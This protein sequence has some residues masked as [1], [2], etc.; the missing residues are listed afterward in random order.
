MTLEG[1]LD[2]LMKKP[3]ID[4]LP[5]AAYMCALDSL[6]D[7]SDLFEPVP[8]VSVYRNYDGPD[9]DPAGEGGYRDEEEVAA[10]AGADQFSCVLV[11][12]TQPVA[13]GGDEGFVF[14]FE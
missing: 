6:L 10:L 8:S 11:S 14:T 2:K 4:L 5:T 13:P 12:D 1:R 3:A 7:S 9:T